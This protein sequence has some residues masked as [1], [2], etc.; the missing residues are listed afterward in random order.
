MQSLYAALSC[1]NT[2]EIALQSRCSCQTLT[3]HYIQDSITL[4][5]KLATYHDG[6]R[7]GQLIV[8]SQN[9]SQAHYATGIAT[10]MRD[11]LDDWNFI[12]PQLEQLYQQLNHGRAPHPFDFDTTRCMAPL[13]RPAETLAANS[14]IRVLD[15]NATS[16][17]LPISAGRLAQAQAIIPAAA[18]GTGHADYAAGIAA[19]TGDIACTATAEAATPA[20]RLLTLACHIVLCHQDINTTEPATGDIADIGFDNY[21]FT[22]CAPIA[23]TP[24]ELGDGWRDGQV[25]LRL[26][27]FRNDQP[28]A[29]MPTYGDHV[30]AI[31]TLLAQAASL[32]TLNAGAILIMAPMLHPDETKG[33]TTVLLKRIRERRDLGTPSTPYLQHGDTLRIE[34]KS[35]D[36]NALFGAI[37][38][39]AEKD[40]ANE[41]QDSQRAS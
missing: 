40:L 22:A 25:H 1:H 3:V 2:G 13:P 15:K 38:L 21:V 8:V 39:K 36:G 9:L 12:A 26:D 31:G 30:D 19:I 23:L 6:S 5:M 17:T 32:H 24:D 27:I 34:M 16:Q 18:I 28:I 20:V 14:C 33:N 10:R 37:A 11:L 29:R 41:N 4:L 7:D 35:T